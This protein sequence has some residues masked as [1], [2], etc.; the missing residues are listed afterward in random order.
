MTQWSNGIDGRKVSNTRASSWSKGGGKES[1][2]QKM[3]SSKLLP[4]KSGGENS[5]LDRKR[6]GRAKRETNTP[7]GGGTSGEGTRNSREERRAKR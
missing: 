2:F 4:I 1:R 7:N 3:G 5:S 6:G